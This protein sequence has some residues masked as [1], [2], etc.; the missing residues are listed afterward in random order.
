[1]TVAM[2]IPIEVPQRR[3]AMNLGVQCNFNLP[4]TP[5]EFYKPPFWDTRSKDSARSEK[6]QSATT[7]TEK[8]KRV[9]RSLSDGYQPSPHN[10]TVI[11]ENGVHFG[12]VSSGDFYSFVNNYLIM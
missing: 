7:T 3:V 10:L 6:D 2:A 1:M 8:E 12:D 5:K 4:Y 9:S 11:G